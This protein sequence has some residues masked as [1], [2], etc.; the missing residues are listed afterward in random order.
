MLWESCR[1]EST[2]QLVPIP[3]RHSVSIDVNWGLRFDD[4]N[5]AERFIGQLASECSARMMEGGIRGGRTFTVKVLKRKD[6]APREPS[7]FMGC[8][9]CDAFSKSTTTLRFLSKA[10]DME[11]E[12]L[13]LFQRIMIGIPVIDLRGIGVQVSKLDEEMIQ[14][15]CWFRMTGKESPPKQRIEAVN[16]TEI[17]LS[18]SKSGC[19]E[20]SHLSLNQDSNLSLSSSQVEFLGT[21]KDPSLVEDIRNDFVAANSNIHRKSVLISPHLNKNGKN[22]PKRKSPSPRKR[23]VPTPS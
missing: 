2:E 17:D 22:G 18:P 9:E 21:L 13:K 11:T 5:K 16:L 15:K 3:K 23:K 10:S 6:N 7:K 19:G 1:G 14:S 4:I 12:F 8:G 20:G